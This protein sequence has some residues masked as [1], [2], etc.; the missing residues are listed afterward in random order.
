MQT[1][2][3]IKNSFMTSLLCATIIL[4]PGCS[5]QKECN[6]LK[7]TDIAPGTAQI[8][9]TIIEIEPLSNDT[10]LSDPCSK[11]PCIALV[12]VTSARYGSAFPQLTIGKEIR[13]KFR[14]TVEKTTKELFPYLNEEY[15]GLQ[16]GD[17]FTAIVSTIKSID[18]T[19]PIFQINGY[20]L[21]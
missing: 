14:Y 7:L 11:A 5:S 6:K 3:N 10:N 8:V 4:S 9:G 17:E 13:V 19:A 2:M 18:K 1:N 21:N 15:P 20:E 12:R 16:V